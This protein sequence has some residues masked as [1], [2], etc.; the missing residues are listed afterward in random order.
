MFHSTTPRF[1]DSA[2]NTARSAPATSHGRVAAVD[3]EYDTDHGAKMTLFTA[4]QQAGNVVPS[5]KSKVRS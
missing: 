4:T 2:P 3:R 5:M 1:S